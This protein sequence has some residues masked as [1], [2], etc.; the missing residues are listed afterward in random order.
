MEKVIAE[1][2]ILLGNKKIIWE[3]GDTGLRTLH[4]NT[5]GLPPDEER[6]TDGKTS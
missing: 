6:K 3:M 5:C 2:R 1:D 4:R